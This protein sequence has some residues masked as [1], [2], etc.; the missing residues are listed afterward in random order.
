MTACWHLLHAEWTKFRTVRGWVIG[1]LVAVGVTVLVGLLGPASSNVSCA[2][3]GGRPCTLANHTPPLGPDG[4]AVADGFYFV[5]QPLTGDG[6]ITAR[7][8]SLTGSVQPWSKTGVIIKASTRQGSAYAAVVATGSHGVRMQYDF[9]HDTAGQPGDPRWL[10][11]TRAGDT[12]TGY[13]STDGTHWHVIS[14]ATL[15][16]LPTT[17]QAGLLATSPGVD[18]PTLATG[19][20]DNV[21]LAGAAPG[22]WIGGD[23]AGLGPGGGPGSGFQQSGGTLTVSGSG[24]IAPAVPGQG[25]LDKTIENG[26]IGVFAGLIAVIIVATLFVT[27]EYR[28]GLIRTTL[29]ASPWRGGVLAAKAVVVGVVTFVAGLVAASIAVPLVARLEHGKGF[30]VYTVTPLTELRVVVGTAALLAVSAVLALAVGTMVR[31]G[32]GAVAAVIVAIVLPYILTIAPV[33][34][35]GAAEW[36]ARLTPA[37]AFAVQQSIPQY[38]QVTASYTPADGFFPL[39]PWAGF[40]VLCGYTA[41]ALVVAFF[42]LHRR[43]A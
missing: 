32:A 18:G 13:D 37:A 25:G 33:L 10:R 16:G 1:M 34:P 31:R 20:F 26:L 23:V 39:A 14:T 7:L 19:T 43:D 30:Y 12:I 22:R 38:T 17:V 9:T 36:L 29:A 11:L 24:D 5:R 42:V 4:E 35:A 6:S 41:I 3:P 2:G 40:G 15:A 27:T 8:T 28:R 21:S